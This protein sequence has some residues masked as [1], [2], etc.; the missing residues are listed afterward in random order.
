MRNINDETVE[1]VETSKL[2]HETISEQNDTA[3][4]IE[5]I[6]VINKMEQQIKEEIKPEER[7][8]ND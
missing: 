8:K 6:N 1:K 4:K 7:G 2:G 3:G 5:V